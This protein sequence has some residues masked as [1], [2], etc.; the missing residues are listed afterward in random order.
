MPEYHDTR[1]SVLAPL[2]T[3]AS[4]VADWPCDPGLAQGIQQ[5]R[6][7]LTRILNGEDDRLVVVAGPCSIHDVDAAREYA[8]LL[9]QERQRLENDLFIIMRCYFEKPRTT[10]GWKGLLVDP[11]LDGSCDIA[12]GLA[13]AR[14]LLLD[15][16]SLKLPAGGEWLNPFLQLPLQDL[17]TWYAIGARTTESPLHREIVS[18]LDM[19]AGFKNNREGN[20]QCAVDAVKTASVPHYYCGTDMNG[21]QS[22]IQTKGNRSCH[23]IL[24]GS[25]MGSNH[26]AA[27][28][29][30]TALRL[31]EAGL[32]PRFFI[33]CSHGN[34]RGNYR[35]QI[36]VAKSL[37]SQIAAGENHLRGIMLESHLVGGQQR[38]LG[39]ACLQYGQSITDPCLSWHETKPL[40]ECLALSANQ[41]RKI[42]HCSAS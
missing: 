11:H 1:Q 31:Q 30:E 3:P 36:E 12:H 22:V 6:H 8:G 38:W 20:I 39:R 7:S 13:K 33:D 24:R 40:L 23:V 2:P 35:R 42:R 18:G 32:E 26:D 28:R 10:L 37:S 9:D 16:A 14:G 5:A 27:S 17:M 4:L 25:Q 15:L 19:P 34:A 21:L 41:R 29:H